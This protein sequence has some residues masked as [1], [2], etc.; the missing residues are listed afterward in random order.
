MPP[1]LAID[2]TEVP[3]GGSYCLLGFLLFLYLVHT[4]CLNIYIYVL[5]NSY[6]Y[7]LVK[8]FGC[9]CM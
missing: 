2:S 3:A 8:Y 6:P 4:W 7:V 9:I 1:A 5:L